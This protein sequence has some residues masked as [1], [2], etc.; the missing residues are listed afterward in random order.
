VLL[1]IVHVAHS[2]IVTVFLALNSNIEVGIIHF[3]NDGFKG[4]HD[5]TR[6]LRTRIVKVTAKVEQGLYNTCGMESKQ[7]RH[8]RII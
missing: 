3:Y 8:G 6:L 2:L 1:T 7:I 5:L 4:E